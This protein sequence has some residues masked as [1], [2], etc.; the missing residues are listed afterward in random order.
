MNPLQSV[1]ISFGIAHPP[2]N[3]RSLSVLTINDR[4]RRMNHHLDDESYEKLK[5]IN[6][7][8][9][10]RVKASRLKDSVILPIVPRENLGG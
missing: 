5:D 6:F 10:V 3:I 1:Q 2:T 8:R 4:I 9:P 7:L